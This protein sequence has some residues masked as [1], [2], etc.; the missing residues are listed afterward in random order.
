MGKS[1]FS[2]GLLV[3]FCLSV[4]SHLFAQDK[5]ITVPRPVQGAPFRVNDMDDLFGKA[6]RWFLEGEVSWAADSLAKLINSSGFQMNPNDYHM[7]VAN[8]TDEM[9]PIGLLHAGSEFADTRFYGL[10]DANLYYIFISKRENANSFLSVTLTRKDS[11]FQASLLDF[12]SLF[13]PLPSIPR[14]LAGPPDVWIDVRKFEIP[15]KFQKNSDFNVIIKKSMDAEDFLASA[16]FDNTAKER[17]SFG[18]ATAITTVDDV[19]FIVDQGKIVIRPKPDGDF[20]MFGVLNYHFQPVDT[21]QPT[22]PSSFHLLA[23]FRLADHFEPIAGLGFGFPTGVPVEVHIFAGVSAEFTDKL[24]SGFQIGQEIQ[25]DVDPFKLDVRVLP[26]FG[27][28]LKFP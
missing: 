14:A 11:P 7:V 28:E 15:E 24:K 25:E 20:A 2:T 3:L 27:L 9:T 22:V 8:F 1:M 10:H 6:Y 13:I 17:W 18:I 12:I 4:C 16:Q 5:I 26:R 19:D 21:K 23:G